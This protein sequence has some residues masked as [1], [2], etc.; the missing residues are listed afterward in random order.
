MREPLEQI[1]KG[2]RAAAIL[3]MAF[4][5]PALRSVTQSGDVRSNFAVRF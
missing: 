3:P 1:D 2:A 5:T 4:M